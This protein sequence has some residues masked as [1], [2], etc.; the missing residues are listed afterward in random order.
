[1]RNTGH[2]HVA[3]EFADKTMGVNG[4]FCRFEIK[5]PFLSLVR[6]RFCVREISAV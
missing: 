6:E 2:W 4:S 3:G 5:R 1:M